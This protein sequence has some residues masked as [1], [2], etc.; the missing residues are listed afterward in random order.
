MAACIEAVLTLSRLR[1]DERRAL[2]AGDIARELSEHTGK[3][4]LILALR[5]ETRRSAT[6]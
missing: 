1:Q 5:Q 6:A 4:E 3:V 2:A